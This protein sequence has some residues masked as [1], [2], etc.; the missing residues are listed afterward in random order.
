MWTVIVQ[1]TLSPATRPALVHVTVPEALAQ[2]GVVADTKLVPA[3]RTSSTVKPTLS[4][5]PR[6]VTLTVNVSSVPAVA[7]SGAAVFS[8]LRSAWATTAVVVVAASLPAVGSVGS[9]ES[10]AAVLLI[11]A[12]S[13]TELATLTTRVQVTLALRARPVLVQVTVPEASAQPALAETKVVPVG[14]ASVRLK[15]ALSDGP[16][17]VT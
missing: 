7:G 10:M 15:P 8:T 13:A 1:V 5:G 17:L 4:D 2:S 9:V 12:P 16:R 11:V 3:G 14:M 6:L